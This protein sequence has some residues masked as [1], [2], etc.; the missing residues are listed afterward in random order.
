MRLIL[1]ILA[2]PFVVVLTL[3]VWFFAFILNFSSFVFGLASTLLAICGVVLLIT[4]AHMNGVIVLVI[5]FLVSPF[6]L[7]MAAVWLLGKLQG[8]N[9]TLRNFITG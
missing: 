1:K 9:Y 2:A 8:L 7:P 4:G 6:G 3:A 5:A